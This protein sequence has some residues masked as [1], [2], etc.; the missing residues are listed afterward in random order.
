MFLLFPPPLVFSLSL[1]SLFVPGCLQ[2]HGRGDALCSSPA[3]LLLIA[4]AKVPAPHYLNS[5][6]AGL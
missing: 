1:S 2:V 6:A 3:S 5:S 4:S